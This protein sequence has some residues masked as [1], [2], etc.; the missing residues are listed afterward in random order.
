MGGMENLA[1]KITGHARPTQETAMADALGKMYK[2][3]Y[4]SPDQ[5]KN[6]VY[7]DPAGV[8]ADLA[9]I[10]G[11]AGAAAK[12][13]ELGADAANFSRVAGAAGTVARVAGQASDLVDPLRVPGRVAGA[14]AKI[15]AVASG[16]D[17]I[18]QGLYHSSLKPPPSTPGTAAMVQTGL[19]N[20]IPVSASGVSKLTDLMDNLNNK[21]KAVIANGKQRGVTI[22]PNAVAQRVDQIRPGFANQVNPDKDL[23]MIDNSKAEFLRNQGQTPGSPAVAPKPTG[24]LDPNGRPILTAGT[25]ATPGTPAQPIPAD[26]AQAMK[27]NT[28][29]QLSY[30]ELKNGQVEAQKALARG[31]KEEIANQFPEISALN[32]KDSKLLDLQP[33]LERAVQRYANHNAVG[34]GPAVVGEAGGRMLGVPGAGLGIGALKMALDNPAVKSHIAIMLYRAG[35]M[36]GKAT[37]AV[38]R[39]KVT[40]IADALAR[41]QAVADSLPAG[42][43]PGQQTDST[44]SSPPEGGLVPSL[45]Q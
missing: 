15:P 21:I 1:D 22:D 13:V 31:L 2:D 28:Y 33:T 7:N 41:V 18:P 30:G 19:E 9:T 11:G 36:S 25:P 5:I 23:Q 16:L 20:G 3:R 44:Q 34:I 26:T 27:Q 37:G 6:T 29:K 38:S 12:G 14:V 24:L 8:A 35:Q 32:A 39:A 40:N 43:R 45:A 42:Q 4:G 17:A 10:F